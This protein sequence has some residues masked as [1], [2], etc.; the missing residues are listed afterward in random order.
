MEDLFTFRRMP[1]DEPQIEDYHKAA[2]E[3]LQTLYP[4]KHINT[5]DMQTIGI[6]TDS[7]YSETG[8]DTYEL[9][10]IDDETPSIR[11]T[12]SEEVITFRV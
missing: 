7:L 4:T 5:Y 1:I 2:V 11:N 9:G 10:F 3:K 6:E 12:R 8:I